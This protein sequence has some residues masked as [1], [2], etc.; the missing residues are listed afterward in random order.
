[1]FGFIS[2]ADRLWLHQTRPTRGIQRS[3][4]RWEWTTRYL[5]YLQFCSL[6]DFLT[7]NF[8]CLQMFAFC[9]I[10][11]V[12]WKRKLQG[13]CTRNGDF[14]LVFMKFFS[15]SV[16][17]STSWKHYSLPLQKTL[18]RTDRCAKCR[19]PFVLDWYLRSQ[20]RST[21]KCVYYTVSYR[22]LI[23]ESCSVNH[24]WK[25]IIFLDGM[26]GKSKADSM[27]VLILVFT[28]F[29]FQW[30]SMLIIF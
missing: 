10:M 14:K 15:A 6:F 22:G 18:V 21:R 20:Q 9:W 4:Q 24:G 25:L 29:F 11:T 27:S 26:K 19:M 23:L 8:Y 30:R 5:T 17:C 3:V 12:C 2:G 16:N 28:F 1:M 13:W 7:E